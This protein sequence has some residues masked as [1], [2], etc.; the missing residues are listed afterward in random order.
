MIRVF[1]FKQVVTVTKS[2]Y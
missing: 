1:H 2:I